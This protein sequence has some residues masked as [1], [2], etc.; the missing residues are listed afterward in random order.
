MPELDFHIDGVEPVPYAASPQLAFK[1]RVTQATRGTQPPAPIHSVLLRCQ[2]RL[3]PARRRYQPD[4]QEK[5]LELFGE[6]H[7]WGQT[8]RSMLWTHTSASVPPFTDQARI[9]LIVPCTYDFNVAATKYFAALD[10]G[11]VPLS[12]LFSGT[13][14]YASEDEVLQV[15]QISWEKEAGFR[16]PVR[17]WRQM[18][19]IYYPNTAW[20]CLRQDIFDRLNRYQRER[21]YASWEQAVETLLE[22]A[23]ARLPGTEVSP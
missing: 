23:E 10:D 2:V 19:D 3:E 14:F 11:E 4:E 8:V 21:G 13:I 12:F 5:L 18:M 17:V 9:D 16:L 20:L 15:E 22:G 7:R 6:P 1:L